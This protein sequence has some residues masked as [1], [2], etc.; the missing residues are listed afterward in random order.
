MVASSSSFAWPA[1]AAA[2][3]CD[4]ER[5]CDMSALCILGCVHVDTLFLHA[6]MIFSELGM[7]GRLCASPS[8]SGN[9]KRMANQTH[10]AAIT[11][12]ESPHY[13]VRIPYPAG[14]TIETS[15]AWCYTDC[16]ANARRL[17]GAHGYWGH[18]H[19]RSSEYGLRRC[20][21]PGAGGPG[22]RRETS[23]RLVLS[24]QEFARAPLVVSQ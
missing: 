23:R 18:F 4:L 17:V 3:D 19:Q 22:G 6:H 1:A 15:Q 2:G 9:R 10:Q 13:V 8:S 24:D 7:I 14:V 21:P 11:D 12:P 5:E 20:A 16:Y